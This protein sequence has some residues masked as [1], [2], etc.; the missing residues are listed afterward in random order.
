M[1]DTTKI[2]DAPVFSYAMASGDMRYIEIGRRDV[3]VRDDP[4][5]GLI[6]RGEIPDCGPGCFVDLSEIL[7][8][9][10]MNC[11]GCREKS[12]AT[13]EAVRFGEHLSEILLASTSSESSELPAVE[14][15]SSAFTF[16]L[17]SM[18]ASYTEENKGNLL[19]YSLEWCPLSECAQCNGLSR[20]VEAAHLTFTSLCNNLITSLAPGW[21]L[22]Q[23]S[24]A[25]TKI[26]IHSIVISGF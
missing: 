15:L 21:A 26:P 13:D 25:D 7:L 17:N 14:R 23:P 6:I 18:N 8:E 2:P 4:D 1:L 19:E 22:M 16:I 11:E 10:V 24:E 12:M 3:Y 9:Y 5:V 20:S